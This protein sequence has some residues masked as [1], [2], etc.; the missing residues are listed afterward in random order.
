MN[1]DL[2]TVSVWKPRAK[3]MS[4]LTVMLLF[5][6]LA[7]L[8]DARA[9]GSFSLYLGSPGMLVERGYPPPR[10]QPNPYAPPGY[11][12]GYDPGYDHRYNR[13]Q[14][15]P[16]R[17]LWVRHA[18]WVWQPGYWSGPRRHPHRHGHDDDDDGRRW[19]R[20]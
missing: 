19:G 15:I 2:S 14:W 4:F 13:G 10:Y 1:T 12:S 9:D 7:S 20:E 5:A 16:G 6:G 18:G 17:W 3:L 8:P 11:G